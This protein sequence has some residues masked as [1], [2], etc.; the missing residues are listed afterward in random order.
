MV[1]SAAWIAARNKGPGAA[2]GS[3]LRC[4]SWSELDA[5]QGSTMNFRIDAAHVHTLESA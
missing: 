2:E 4:A 3:V 1:R 5:S